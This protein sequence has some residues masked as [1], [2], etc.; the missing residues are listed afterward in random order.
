[1]AARFEPRQPRIKPS[2]GVGESARVHFPSVTSLDSK[3]ILH[4]Q[5]SGKERNSPLGAKEYNA[6]GRPGCVRSSEWA[7][8]PHTAAAEARPRP[9]PGTS[10]LC[11]GAAC[12]L[13][14]ILAY[15]M[16]TLFKQRRIK[17]LP[18]AFAQ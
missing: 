7:L 16:L 2:S 18:E 1:M 3:P 6:L 4:T 12:L 13:E 10:W 15:M 8:S 5:F 17:Q 11:L 14:L 9:F